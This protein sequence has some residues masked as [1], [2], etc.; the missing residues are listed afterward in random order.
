VNATYLLD[1]NVLSEPLRSVPNRKVLQR[2][3]RFEDR[4]VTASVVWNELQ[5][6]ASRLPRSNKRSAIEKYLESVVGATIPILPYD[7][8]AARWHAAERAR[9]EKIGKTP[10]FVDSQIAA[11]AKVNGLT[12]VTRNVVD[13]SLFEDLT[14]EDWYT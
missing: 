12:L 3:R 7:E 11:T 14:L 9:L 1:T 4:I 6:G 13:Y 5:Y 8:K 2:L 10:A